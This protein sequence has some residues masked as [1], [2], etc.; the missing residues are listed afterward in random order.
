MVS[1]GGGG[2]SSKP[3][4]A[5]G[6]ILIWLEAAPT[7]NNLKALLVPGRSSL[8][9]EK[10]ISVFVSVVKARIKGHSLA[11]QGRHGRCT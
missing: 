1:N 9:T 4:S 7:N 5:I 6:F 2:G 8:L 10:H 3:A 11:Q